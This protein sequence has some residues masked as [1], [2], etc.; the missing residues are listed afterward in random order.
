MYLLKE[1]KQTRSPIKNVFEPVNPL[2]KPQSFLLAG[3]SNKQSDLL[4][5]INKENIWKRRFRKHHGVTLA[6]EFI[7]EEHLKMVS[8]NF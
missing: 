7:F 6:Y 3:K 8:N 1:N 4:P 2:E 5:T